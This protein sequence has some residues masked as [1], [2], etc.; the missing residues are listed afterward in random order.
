MDDEKLIKAI[1]V[2]VSSAMD[3]RLHQTVPHMHSSDSDVKAAWSKFRDAAIGALVLGMGY[4]A[5]NLP[6][7]MNRLDTLE[8]NVQSVEK[9]TRDN[10]TRQ[11]W[12]RESSKGYSDLEELKKKV[13]VLDVRMDDLTQRVQILELEKRE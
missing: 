7:I 11:D 8:Q 5:I 6:V 12:V 13:E 9:N 1:S 10:F 2:A 4:V 3:Q